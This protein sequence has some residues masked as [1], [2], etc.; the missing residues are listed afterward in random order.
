MAG[1]VTHN[2]YVYILTNKSKTVRYTGVTN[3]LKER[4]HFHRNPT[5]LS[6][7]FTTKYRCYFL[8]YYEHFLS[9]DAAI[10]REKQ[11]KGY[12]RS[13][14]EDLINDFNPNWEFLND[15]I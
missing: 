8:I 10:Q 7:A 3:S 1:K 13:K 9:I 11:I 6:R 2:Y 5:A 12:R 14:K 15:K 4:I